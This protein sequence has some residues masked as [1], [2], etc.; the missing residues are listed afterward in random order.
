MLLLPKPVHA[1]SS[2]T[3]LELPDQSLELANHR[4]HRYAFRKRFHSYFIHPLLELRF[5]ARSRLRSRP[6]NHRGP[7]PAPQIEP[8]LLSQLPVGPGY[9]VV[10]NPEIQGELTDRR[11]LVAGPELAGQERSTQASNDLFRSGQL[12]GQVDLKH[13]RMFRHSLMYMYNVLCYAPPRQAPPT[14]CF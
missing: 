2:F 8:A 4:F 12:G 6:L 5:G 13:R 7:A 3:F 9:G 1:A 14:P 10:M 11:K